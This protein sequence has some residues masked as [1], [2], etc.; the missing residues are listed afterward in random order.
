VDG[1]IRLTVGPVPADVAREWI[2]NSRALVAAVHQHRLA[3]SI[4][5]RPPILELIDAVLAVWEDV[6]EEAPVFRWESEVDVD[7]L[8]SL[9]KEWRELAAM[10]PEDL[11]VLGVA[12]A[13]ERTAPMFDAVVAALAEALQALPSTA[14]VGVEL[15]LRPPGRE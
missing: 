9:A 15:L 13:D 12:W 6:A 10:T 4:P 8:L 3:L 2:A 14:V 5:V 1:R 11:E 7:Q